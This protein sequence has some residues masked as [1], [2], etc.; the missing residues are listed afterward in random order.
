MFGRKGNLHSQF[1]AIHEGRRGT[2]E[3]AVI[4]APTLHFTRLERLKSQR[5]ANTRGNTGR[6][7]TVQH[8]TCMFET[9]PAKPVP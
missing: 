6:T 9:K 2:E 4:L 5:K 7:V 1:S 3:D 8:T